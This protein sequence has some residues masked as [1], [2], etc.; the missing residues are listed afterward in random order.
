MLLAAVFLIELLIMLLLPVILPYEVDAKMTA[1]IDATVL[2]L[3]L[4]PLI[5][6]FVIKPL[7]HL[8]DECDDLIE[9]ELSHA[10][11]F[12][13]LAAQA[14][15]V[16]FQLE[17]YA[18]G[19]YKL[20]FLN[21]Q[22]QAVYRLTQGE[23]QREPELF[24]SLVH[25]EDIAK[26]R[27][28]ILLSTQHLSMLSHE[29]RLQFQNGDE[30]KLSLHAM[31]RK[32]STGTIIFSGFIKPIIENPE[33]KLLRNIAS[34]LYGIPLGLVITDASN[35]IKQVNHA[36][37]MI[38]GYAKDELLGKNM[39]L[40]KSNSHDSEFYKWI[41]HCVDVHGEW[42]GEIWSKRKNGQL[43][44]QRTE[45]FAITNADGDTINYIGA[46]TDIT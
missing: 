20:P 21:K 43:Y 16:F 2:S 6:Y 5:F 12:N 23:L 33:L 40:M 8:K 34:D 17:V 7:K 28:A 38:S 32:Q 24:F 3:I 35:T 37:S 29:Y 14:D 4:C 10:D 27:N 42:Q 36:F 26:L 1:I 13:N 22:F 46:M 19:T 31:P 44:L 11:Q 15:G 9:N 18:D 30:C 41:W 45:I 25:P 39:R